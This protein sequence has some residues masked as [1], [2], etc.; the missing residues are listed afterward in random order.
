MIEVRID[1]P[2][3]IESRAVRHRGARRDVE[4]EA[5]R[6]VDDLHVGHDEI[7]IGAALRNR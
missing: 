7:L 6:T 2:E 5:G 4:I 3:D 1:S